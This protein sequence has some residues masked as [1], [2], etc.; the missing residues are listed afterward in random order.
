MAENIRR[1]VKR[2]IAAGKRE[3]FIG[4]LD[5]TNDGEAMAKAEKEFSGYTK[6][7]VEVATVYTGM[8]IKRYAV[9]GFIRK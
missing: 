2:Q 1:K 8:E 4:G 7:R 9:Y 5:A 3:T 6:L